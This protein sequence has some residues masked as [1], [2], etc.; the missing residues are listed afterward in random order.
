[1]RFSF[2]LL[3]GAGAVLVHLYLY[4]GLVRPL[5]PS[6]NWRRALGGVLLGL[7]LLLM[8]RGTMRDLGPSIGQA[9]SVTSYS[10]M[11][12]AVC[13]MC[14]IAAGDLVRVGL[15]ARSFFTRRRVDLRR[16]DPAE[17]APPTANQPDT[18]VIDEDRR[19]FVTGVLPWSVAAGGGLLTGYGMV[20]AFTPAEIT[21]TPIPIAKLPRTL[22]GL[23]IVQLTDI[24]VGPFVGRGFIDRLVEQANALSPDVLVITGDL[25]DGDVDRLGPAVAGLANLRARF[26]TYFVTGNH[27]Y[28]SGDVAW[29][30]FLE[31]LGI[32]VLRN[33][34]VPIGDGGGTFD[35]VGV[36]DWSGARRRGKTG[37]DLEA[38][39]DGRDPDRAAV[40]LA[41]QPTNFDVATAR[42]V[43]LQVSGHTH[44]GQLFPMTM[45][46][47]L[48]YP[49]TRGLY[50]H[51]D[52]QI[53]VSRGCGFW[54]PPARVG[55]PPEIAKLVLTV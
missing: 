39:L 43:D 38:A 40:L 3:I 29:A 47:G 41:H 49:Y 33:R 24:H 22:D 9:Y 54:G 53:Y 16:H 13:M 50:R 6:A 1:M 11:A 42:G 27:D 51:G 48:R 25:V 28:Y 19:R 4:R 52:G 5:S 32:T 17:A 18:P 7:T 12:L 15:A 45:L 44:G 36:D 35:L 30:R 14:A 26:G 37:Y 46:V 20:R 34:R 21:E 31:R 55:S 8:A 23:T 2:S 10:W